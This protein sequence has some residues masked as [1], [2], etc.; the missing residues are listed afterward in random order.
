MRDMRRVNSVDISVRPL[1]PTATLTYAK[2]S[3][4]EDASVP[5]QTYHGTTV[6][7]GKSAPVNM[8][9]WNKSAYKLYWPGNQPNT[10]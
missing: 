4:E 1:G 8:V 3:G 2:D 5:P 9:V 10:P 6:G 7:R